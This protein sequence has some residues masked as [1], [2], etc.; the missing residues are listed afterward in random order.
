[1]SAMNHINMTHFA[2]ICAELVERMYEKD[3]KLLLHKL[4]LQLGKRLS[5]SRATTEPS[6]TGACKRTEKKGYRYEG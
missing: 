2:R 1:M 4:S 5:M 3:F 6:P